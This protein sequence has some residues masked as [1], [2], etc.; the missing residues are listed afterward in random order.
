LLGEAL[1]KGDCELFI[2]IF[3]GLAREDDPGDCK[4]ARDAFDAGFYARALDRWPRHYANERRALAAYKKKQKADRAM[5]AIDKRMKRLYVS[6]FQS[7][8]FNEVAAGRIR[9]IDRV[10][11]G[12]LAQKTDTGGIFAVE[13]AAAEQPRAESFQISPTGPIPGYRSNLATGEPGKIE[14]DALV[15]FGVELEDFRRVIAMKVK[16]TRRALRFALI[17]PQ[18]AAGNDEHGE[19]LELAFAAAS[20]CYATVALRELMKTGRQ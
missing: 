12:D 14:R 7:A 11:V 13:D 10:L 8:V 17:E 6:A 16:G 20:G 3:L 15:K 5:A 19:Y 9:S 4:A 2:A 1:V 18:L